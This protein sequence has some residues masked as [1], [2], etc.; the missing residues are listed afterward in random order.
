MLRDLIFARDSPERRKNWKVVRFIAFGLDLPPLILDTD[1]R[2][3]DSMA[4]ASDSMMPMG[5]LG[6]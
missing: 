4:V 1:F 5:V 2:A 6:G 3:S